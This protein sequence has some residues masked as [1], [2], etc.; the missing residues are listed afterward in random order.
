MMER[1]LEIERFLSISSAVPATQPLP[2]HL[3]LSGLVAAP[4][5]Y[6][7]TMVNTLSAKYYDS[8]SRISHLC[9]NLAIIFAA[10]G[11]QD[12]YAE[13]RSRR[14]QLKT[15]GLRLPGVPLIK[16]NMMRSAYFAPSPNQPR[17]VERV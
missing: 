8:T 13:R 17:K 4:L 7:D 16:V 11:L 9:N 3:T 5:N 12:I 1:F 14:S 15:T 10:A 6:Q 2:L